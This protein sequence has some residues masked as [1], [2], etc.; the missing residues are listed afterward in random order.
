MESVTTEAPGVVSITAKGYRLDKMKTASGQFFIWRFLDRP[1]WSR[2]NPYT[3]SA[4]PTPE[5]LRITIKAA[6][7][8]SERA[9]RLI[10]G[11][12]ILIESPYGTLTARR[13]TQPRMLLI[14]AG[15]GITTMRA[16]LE[17]TPYAPRRDQPHL[18]LQ[19]RPARRVRRR[20]PRSFHGSCS[21]RREPP[22]CPVRT[23]ARTCR[24]PAGP[25]RASQAPARC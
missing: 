5:R 25:A 14:A 17:D 8:G 9:A 11:T 19:R 23:G 21:A 24:G 15:I 1:G 20:T 4:A 2:G 16:L 10:P 7:D 13:R 22:L 6:G 3:L 18:P 12:R